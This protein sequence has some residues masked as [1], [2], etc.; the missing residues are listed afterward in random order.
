M[1]Y[2][3]RLD[4]ALIVAEPQEGAVA[5]GVFTTNRFCAHRWSGA[6]GVW[7]LP[8]KRHPR[9]CG[10][11][12]RCT[13]ERRVQTCRGNGPNGGEALN[14][15]PGDILISSTGVIGPQVLLE[16]VQK[17]MPPCQRV[18]PR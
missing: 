1:R 16:P 18:A 17:S 5:A 10:Y 3:N 4:L 15:P 14:A 6:G 13:G 8:G 9:Q 11:C 7:I 12:Q 2:R